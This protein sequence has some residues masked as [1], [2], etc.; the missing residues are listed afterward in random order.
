MEEDTDGDGIGDE[1]TLALNWYDVTH[2]SYSDYSIAQNRANQGI[3][4]IISP[5]ESRT[6]TSSITSSTNSFQSSISYS[7]GGFSGSLYKQGSSF[8]S[9]GSLTPADSKTATSTCE[10][11]KY[12]RYNAQGVWVKSSEDPACPS[13]MPYSSGGYTGTLNRTTTDTL[14]TCAA[15]GGTP[16]SY[17][18]G[19]WRAN[20]SGTVNKPASDTRMYR[21]NYSGTVFK[22]TVLSSEKYG[23]WV[24]VSS[25]YKWR[26]VYG[27]SNTRVESREGTPTPTTR[28]TVL[29]DYY[30]QAVADQ[31]AIQSSAGARIG[32]EGGYNYYISNSP[33]AT[34][35]Y[36]SVGTTTG[37]RY[38]NTTKQSIK[39][40]LYPIGKGWSW[41]LPYVE[42]EANKQYVHLAD[43]GRYE[44]DN[45]SLKGTTWLGLSFTEDTSLT[46]SGTVSKYRLTSV[47]G[48][49]KQYF[50]QEGHLLQIADAYDNTISFI[51]IQNAIYGRKL[52]SQIIDSIG[53]RI[54]ISYTT[55]EVT[56]TKGS[57]T[58]VYHKGLDG[59]TE[60]L[61]SVVDA[62][63]RQTTY[64]YEN[65]PAKF[66]LLGYDESR[67]KSNP[68]ILLTNVQHPTGANTKY[69]YEA[70][71]VKRYI[72]ST[73]FVEAYRM[74]SR[75]DVLIFENDTKETFNHHAM[76]YPG[77]YAQS[78][79][80]NMT[81]N[82]TL[83]NG[84]TSTTF[85]YRK[86]FDSS[87]QQANFYLDTQVE[88]GGGIEKMTTNTYAKQVGTRTYAVP[89]PTT[90][91]S[92]NNQT[93]DTLTTTSQYDD[94]GNVTQSVDVLGATTVNTY[95]PVKKWLTSTLQQV[96]AGQYQFTS[97]SRN[98]QGDITEI[99]VRE[100]N[101]SGAILRQ[102]TFGRSG[103]HGNVTTSTT[104]N[105]AKSQVVTYEYDT[106]YQAFPVKQFVNV[107]NADGQ[108]STIKTELEY[109]SITGR[110]VGSIDGRGNRTEYA[111]DKL[112]RIE[113]VTYP[114]NVTLMAE[115][116]DVLN[117]VL[118]TDEEGRQSKVAWN[119]LGW[120][121]ESGVIL[122]TGYAMRSRSQYDQHGRVTATFDA[123]GNRTEYNQDVW[124]RPTSIIYPNLKKSTITYHDNLRE[125]V[126]TDASGNTIVESFD[127]FGRSMRTE[128]LALSG[129]RNLVSQ[130][131][132]FPVNGLLHQQTD[133]KQNTTTYSYDSFGQLRTLTNAKNETTTY[134][135]DNLGNHTKTIFPDGIETEKIYDEL[136]RLIENIDP[137]NN[138]DTYFYDANGNR[139]KL[140][141]KLGQEFTYNYTN[142]NLLENKVGPTETIAFIY[143]DDGSR[144]SMT[145][146]TGTTTY[147]YHPYT[148][149]LDTVTYPDE[150][151]I[152]YTYNSQGIKDTMTTP[153]GD[154]IE[155]NYNSMNQLET[156]E[157]NGEV[158]SSYTYKDNGQL[159]TE[160]LGDVMSSERTYT[161]FLLTEL[162]QVGLGGDLDRVYSY[163]HDENKNIDVLTEMNQSVVTKDLDFSYDDLNRIETSTQF[164][165]SYTYDN[166]GNRQTL[167][168]EGG[169]LPPENGGYQYDEWDRLKQVTRLD[170]TI[171][172]YRYN[173][174]N[175]M[176]ERSENGET[177]R[178]YYDGQQI[179]AE[180]IVQADGIVVEKVSYLRGHGLSMLEEADDTKGY[181]VQNGHGDVVSILGEDGE[182]LNSYDYD[183]WG[184]PIAA[185]ETLSN[186]FRYSGE[187]WDNTTELQ[188]LRA[189]WYDPSIG[190]FINEDTYEGELS[191]PLS[192]NLYTYVHNNPLI[193]IDPSGNKIVLS[194]KATEAEKEAYERA[195]AYLET[196]STA[197]DLIKLLEDSP[198][199]FT[200]EFIDNHDMKYVP[201][202]KTISWDPTSGLVL[203]DKK[204][205]QSAAL[206]LAHEM[207]HASQHLEGLLDEKT[208]MT[209]ELRNKIEAD[210]LSRF[211]TPIA[212]ELGEYTRKN[213]ADASG[214]YR[215]SN[216]TDWGALVP[217]R[218]KWHYI[219]PW[220]WGKP[221][222]AFENQNP[223]TP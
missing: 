75:S 103:S 134:H 79:G 201:S 56:I 145:D 205:I 5:S 159:W 62:E 192:L 208:R 212:K 55:T 198:E 51:Y 168:T 161:N 83:H 16:N 164:N 147:S 85:N 115:Y 34:I 47:D 10:V 37:Y 124:R 210:N 169:A 61:E 136:G 129:T 109:D 42:T 220:N 64:S 72:G 125:V 215:M 20:Y 6:E 156:L 131:S 32:S 189:R 143:N 89:Y 43:G 8:V 113:L 97:Y 74:L 175:L 216:S 151:T 118:I 102:E 65:M 73:S 133:A 11:R 108:L 82:T 185:T 112:G 24:S 28:A 174:D 30:S 31:S 53:N 209:T 182:I 107:T 183:V 187:Y 46:V 130:Q 167:Q 101:E 163:D 195:I 40:M 14:N 1:E 9:S 180:G 116:D 128:E 122:A 71:P 194:N 95:H 81:F 41:K 36:Q 111:Y 154:V 52:L 4:Y 197:A 63:D 173:G 202:T 158:E 166:R 138:K 67:A 110:V 160:N 190:R 126:T 186:S 99:I 146:G 22:P 94:Y 191:N 100:N 27:I 3:Y 221:G 139:S 77:D 137:L 165:E 213:Y 66:N 35:M 69:D 98:E 222:K 148:G 44:V 106:T 2:S 123:D 200:I 219:A 135:Y 104:A 207:G 18:T 21:Q 7:Q 39:D 50:S 172:M 117:T 149:E 38:I 12:G 92:S 196:S 144:E 13:S 49:M 176:V 203:G 58:V 162:T 177:T 170:G 25:T 59:S 150:E 155:Y 80:Q 171:V 48:T 45:G 96:G 78:Y 157:W 153:F 120:Q 54:Q 132:Y 105:G 86:V 88:S 57:E 206:G 178:F 23:E 119:G 68:Y 90:I 223:W 29:R 214:T 19:H 204:S 184:N 218:P 121:Q 199:V 211:E 17:C 87:S 114:G 193:Y 179:I 91:V 84:L 142:R 60:V 70:A 141:D 15:S 33:G 217:T 93:P 152:S 188:Y 140:I 181:Y 127:A 26:Y 76:T